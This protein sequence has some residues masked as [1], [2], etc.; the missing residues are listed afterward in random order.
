MFIKKA[1]SYIKQ[2]NTIVLLFA[3]AMITKFLA[4]IPHIPDIAIYGIQII[5]AIY[6]ISNMQSIAIPFLLLLAYLP[7]EILV[8]GPP[9]EFKSI[10]RYILFAILIISSS[11]IIQSAK[12]RMIRSQLLDI[13]LWV[14]TA[15]GIISVA[16]YFTGI[17]GMRIYGVEDA[18][19]HAGT[20]GGATIHSMLLGPIAASGAIFTASKAYL[21][22]DKWYWLVAALCLLSVLLSASRVALLACMV[23]ITAM[24]YSLTGGKARFLQISLIILLIAAITYPLWE[25][26]TSMIIE[27]QQANIDSGG[28]LD[29]R[30][31][32]WDARITEFKSNPVFGY[33]FS[34]VDK[35]YDIV[36]GN[37]VI[38]PGS[39]WLAILSMTGLIGAIIIIPLFLSIFNTIK[40]RAEEYDSLLIGLLAFF[41]IHMIAEGYIFAAGS[42]VSFFL[43]LVVGCCYDRRY[44]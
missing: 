8:A 12:L 43:W 42:Y 1:I 30:E 2:Y 11:A 5:M 14:S 21:H 9:A 44:R 23:G 15:V 32:K 27:K 41:A 39:S 19:I 26:F 33:G 6:V 36:T 18:A 22:K 40:R 7:I 38:E 29:S 20:F 17:N 4:F 24:L 16:F 10:E 25:N 3:I 28:M 34:A 31:S 37:G 35:K 13:I